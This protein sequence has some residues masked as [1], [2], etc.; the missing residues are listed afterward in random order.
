MRTRNDPVDQVS[1]Y[2]P[3]LGHYSAVTQ[4]NVV[5]L[6]HFT[7]SPPTQLKVCTVKN[8]VTV[9]CQPLP[10]THNQKVTWMKENGELPVGRSKASVDG[11][12]K[13]WNPKVEDSGRYFCTATSNNI[14]AK[15]A[16]TM[17]LT[18]K[19]EFK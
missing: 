3:C 16:S 7:I 2:F 18:V 6:P 9:R 15:A 10:G 8:E 17:K 1:G 5:E 19:R 12:L 14:L 11:T 13:F 4:L